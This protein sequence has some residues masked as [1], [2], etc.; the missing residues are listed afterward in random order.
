MIAF[1]SGPV[2][3]VN[4]T[5]AV[6]EV[7]GVGM[8]VHC[9]PSTLAGLDVGEP[10]KLFTALVVREDSMTLYGFLTD[11]ERAVFELLQTASGIG[12][13]VAQA[14]LSVHA[15]DTL[16]MIFMTGDEA[17]LTQVPGIGKKGAQRLLLELK[18]R[19]GPPTG[20]VPGKAQNGWS[21]ACLCSWIIQMLEALTGL[22]WSAREA[23]DAVHAVAPLAAEQ[24]A[25]GQTVQL[26]PLL[27]A[28]LRTMKK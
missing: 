12:P 7:G 17:A 15:P 27:K 18:E 22:G 16:R 4:P 26:G 25:N 1:V 2:A 28:A 10:A 14:M 8:L 19:L 3:A 9:G 20:A 24:E 23:D 13:K 6:V 21:G 5:S 11:D